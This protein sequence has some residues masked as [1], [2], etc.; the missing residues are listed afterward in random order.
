MFYIQ[1]IHFFNNTSY[2]FSPVVLEISPSAHGRQS[3]QQTGKPFFVARLVPG[4]Q[5]SLQTDRGG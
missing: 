4:R 1:C 2:F 3:K 5:L